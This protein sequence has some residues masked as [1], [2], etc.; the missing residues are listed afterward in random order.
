MKLPESPLPAY[1][2]SHPANR[3]RRVV[4]WVCLVISIAIH[5][6]AIGTVLLTSMHRKPG[7]TVTYIDINSITESG[8]PPAIPVIHSSE[9]QADTD[10]AE[11][12][13]L[14]PGNLSESTNTETSTAPIQSIV[15]EV[16][17]TT[18]GRAM[19]GG[20]FSSFAEGKNLRDDI[21]EYYFV[22][23]EKINARWWLK[24]ETLTATAAHDGVIIFVIGRDGALVDV[25]LSKGTGSREVDRAII[26]VIKD[27]APFPPLPASY[28][29]D[30]FRAPLRIAAP[31]RLFSIRSLR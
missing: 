19:A 5:I 30:M 18:L 25:Q 23:L 9:P 20:Y 14:L 2:S 28:S 16:T 21:R 27:T 7:Q 17:A 10:K 29:L 11:Q 12:P 31:L 1:Y 24:T 3:P 22:L 26:D 4:V 13:E 15:Q 6:V 8:P